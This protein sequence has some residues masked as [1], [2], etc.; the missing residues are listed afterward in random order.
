MRPT[1]SAADGRRCRAQLSCLL[2]GAEYGAPRPSPGPRCCTRSLEDSA[3]EAPSRKASRT[4]EFDG[5]RASAIATGRSTSCFRRPTSVSAYL[6]CGTTF[7][8]SNCPRRKTTSRRGRPAR[9]MPPS[10]PNKRCAAS[11]QRCNRAPGTTSR[12]TREPPCCAASKGGCR[13]TVC[14]TCRR[15]YSSWSTHRRRPRRC[16]TTC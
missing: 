16:S 9:S 8:A 3:Q 6:I 1:R 14:R 13:S 5:M 10:P 15:T 7:S 4:P 11:W 2:A 12:T